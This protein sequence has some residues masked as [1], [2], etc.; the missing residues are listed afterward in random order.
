MNRA[1]GSRDHGE[2][3]ILRETER[4]RLRALVAA[5]VTRARQLHADDFQL[6]NPLGGV[7]SKDEYLGAIGSG[8]VNYL[9]WEADTIAVRIY[10]DVAIVRYQS[11]LE[12]V[13]QGN[14]IPRQRYWHTDV[15]ERR[16]GQWQVVWSHATGIQ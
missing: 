3:D 14:H 11:Q 15:Y 13:V 9:F 4:E 7:L 16:E 8:V 5:D 12:I 2:A 6:I 1:Q 10:G